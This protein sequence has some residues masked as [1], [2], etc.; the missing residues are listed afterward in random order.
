[1]ICLVML[2]EVERLDVARRRSPNLIEVS[3][4]IL[5]GP[6]RLGRAFRARGSLLRSRGQGKLSLIPIFL[7]SPG[8]GVP[9]SSTGRS[10]CHD[11]Q[12]PRDDGTGSHIFRPD[13]PGCRFAR[14]L[15]LGSTSTSSA[16]SSPSPRRSRRHL[17]PLRS[18]CLSRS[19][20]LF[21]LVEVLP[22]PPRCPPPMPRSTSDLSACITRTTS[23]ET[24][25]SAPGPFGSPFVPC[26]CTSAW[27]EGERAPD[28]N[29]L[30][31]KRLGLPRR[32]P[33]QGRRRVTAP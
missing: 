7:G 1:M 16:C 15:A 27:R 14:P 30:A 13:F 17:E 23:A 28:A 10:R 24:F 2:E 11:H 9:G 29:P 6:G 8:A 32:H 33:P 31:L 12:H 4:L 25:I 3:E 26:G 21:V 20:S 18:Q 5:V 22:V 19:G